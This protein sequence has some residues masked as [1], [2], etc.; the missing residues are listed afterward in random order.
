MHATGGRRRSPRRLLVLVFAVAL[1]TRLGFAFGLYPF[2]APRFEELDAYDTIARS[3]VFEGRWNRELFVERLP[4]YPAVLALSYEVFGDTDIPWKALQ[5]LLGAWS[6]ALLFSL[7]SRWATA[8]AAALAAAILCFHPAALLYT[9]R[10][11]TETF[12]GFLVL[13]SFWL[14]ALPGAPAPAL[15]CLWGLQALT[16]SV[17]WIHAP[18]FLGVRRPR[19][20]HVGVSLGVLLVVLPWC[21]VTYRSFGRPLLFTATSGRALYH[22]WYVTTHVGWFEGTGDRNR[23]AQIELVRELA[24]RYGQVALRDWDVARRD[25]AAW[26]LA[27]EKIGARKVDALFLALRNLLLTWTLGRLPESTVLYTIL[28]GFVLASAIVGYVRLRRGKAA[29]TEPAGAMAWTVVAYTVLHAV[30]HPGV[31]YVLPVL[32]LALALAAEPWGRLA[33]RKVPGAFTETVQ[34]RP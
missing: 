15:G 33:G 11:M 1:G 12:Y 32:P 27:L 3:L 9:P 20:W 22:G 16:K 24:Q 18:A 4:A 5:C 17:A 14:L 31:R 30:V 10:P 21:V 25:R 7:A 19:A 13:G 8:P 23:E 28:H 2:L 29:E 6:C 26:D 34:R